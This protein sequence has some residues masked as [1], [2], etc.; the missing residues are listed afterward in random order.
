MWAVVIEVGAPCGDEST[1][2]TQAV[3]QVLVQTFIAHPTVEAFHEAVLHWFSWGDVMPIDLA[4]FLPLQ[5]RIRSQFCAV[6]PSE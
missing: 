3:E 1:G 5:D 4:L 6:T 2:M